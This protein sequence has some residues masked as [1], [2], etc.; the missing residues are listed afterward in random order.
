MMFHAKSTI[1]I[2]KPLLYPAEL[3]DQSTKF[4]S[5]RMCVGNPIS[6]SIAPAA[7]VQAAPQCRPIPAVGLLP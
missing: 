1:R 4:A 6:Y 3:R 5:T 2:R 7:T